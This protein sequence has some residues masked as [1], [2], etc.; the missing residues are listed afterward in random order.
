MYPLLPFDKT[1]KSIA[2]AMAEVFEKT[3]KGKRVAE[4]P[5][6]V[7]FFRSYFGTTTPN[8][9]SLFILC[10][11]PDMTI[12]EIKFELDRFIESNG[13]HYTA[14]C[15]TFKQKAFPSLA[16]LDRFNAH[17]EL[18]QT[19]Q[20]NIDAKARTRHQQLLKELQ[21]SALSL[22]SNKLTS[23]V[24]ETEDKINNAEQ[25]S[26]LAH[27]HKEKAN[28]ELPFHDLYFG[29][30]SAMEIAVDLSYI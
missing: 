13:K 27:W 9:T 6:A 25:V 23:W 26:I 4:H 12:S 14:L 7:A 21:E 18:K 29:F 15:D 24:N 10:N 8:R 20:S 30:G 3:T 17:Y 5:F 1:Q 22:P 16:T 11:S 28:D 19:Q 2:L